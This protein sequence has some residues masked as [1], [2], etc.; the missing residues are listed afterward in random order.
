MFAF[1]LFIT[2]CTFLPELKVG[3]TTDKKNHYFSFTEIVQY[4]GNFD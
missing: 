3:V 2:T 4:N 1:K